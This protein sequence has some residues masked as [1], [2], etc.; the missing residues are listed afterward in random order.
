MGHAASMDALYSLDTLS[1][2][3]TLMHT[4]VCGAGAVELPQQST[5]RMH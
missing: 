4:F 3:A 5:P 2:D 1:A